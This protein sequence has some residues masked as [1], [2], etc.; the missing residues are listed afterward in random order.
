MESVM[1]QSTRSASGMPLP[2][3]KERRSLREAKAMSCEEVAE[4]VGVTAATVRAW[5][6]GRSAPRGRKRQA[7]A[8]LLATIRA[9]L[10]AGAAT[11]PAATPRPPAPEAGWAA[12]PASPSDRP[13][14]GGAAAGATAP[15]RPVPAAAH[16]P[17]PAEAFDAL[18][19]NAAPALVRQAY[20]LTGRRALALEAV[21]R[22]FQQ[23]WQRWPEVATDPDPAGW[24]RAAAYEYALS[25]WHRL[26]RAHREPDR[27]PAR[28][29]DRALLDALL[30]LSPMHRRTLL[31]YDGV[32]LDLPET[33]AETEA[34]TPAAASRLLNARAVVA[35]RLPEVGAAASAAEQSS[36]LHTRLTEL[37]PVAPLVPPPARHVRTTGEHRTQLWTRAAI[38]LT[39]A[40]LAAT[41]LALATAPTRYE[42]PQ[43]PGEAV[44]GVPPHMGP[45]PLTPQDKALRK[46]L[47]AEP[48]NGPERLVPQP[49]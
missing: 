16:A 27:P 26:R 39:T 43:P 7:Y 38:G 35:E 28:A 31:L 1:T 41:L 2:T 30:E 23:A 8:K 18:Y 46:K 24:V 19:A 22:A 14:W 34:S 6:A 33:A 17:S 42:P 13:A 21:E 11:G 29:E 20:L 48:A 25:P 9:E 40:L 5:E 10:E 4:A 15:P 47:Q 12:P 45:Q 3:P 37:T 32:G 44:P 36:V 49:H